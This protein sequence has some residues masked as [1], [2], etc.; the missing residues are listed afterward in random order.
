MTTT[1]S[2]ATLLATLSSYGKA[3]LTTL[4]DSM[5]MSRS[6]PMG[7]SN[8][9][10]AAV[11]LGQY[12]RVS[13]PHTVVAQVTA[14]LQAAL[15][16]QV[17]TPAAVS[18]ALPVKASQATP[19][20]KCTKCGDIGEAGVQVVNGLCSRHQHTAPQSLPLPAAVKVPVSTP[21][22]EARCRVESTVGY[23]AQVATLLQTTP[24]DTVAVCHTLGL[25]A[26]SLQR[27][28]DVAATLVSTPPAAPKAHAPTTPAALP[29]TVKPAAAAP[30]AKP[31][32]V[33]VP[34][35]VTAVKAALTEGTLYSLEQG[36][37]AAAVSYNR[38]C[39]AAMTAALTTWL[40]SQTT[41]PAAG[42]PSLPPQ[43]PQGTV[44]DSVKTQGQVI[45]T[46][47]KMAPQDSPSLAANLDDNHGVVKGSGL[48]AFRKLQ[49]DCKAAGLK[50][51]GK[52]AD[53]T[54]RLAAHKAAAPK[55]PIAKAAATVTPTVLA[56]TRSTLAARLAIA[57]ETLGVSAAD[58]GAAL[59]LAA[60]ACN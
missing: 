34:G 18:A 7:S 42:L 48:A 37:K 17:S 43:A 50:A 14:M 53:L 36:C 25:A 24:L 46:D 16:P 55:A 41:T 45:G 20:A 23:L 12:S 1:Y 40:A 49:A 30:Q 38:N 15:A 39:S 52:A 47:A 56:I 57:A 58:L 4:C 11:L 21:T 8:S 51:D 22:T 3:K 10:K 44:A 32:A 60:I 54:A 35:L 9:V 29:E 33:V 19:M 27:A 59:D 2:P 26:T 6:L 31:A 28:R 13:T 5:G